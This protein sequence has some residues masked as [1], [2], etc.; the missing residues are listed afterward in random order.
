M[1][2]D[3][4][5]ELIS[6]TAVLLISA[7]CTSCATRQEESGKKIS[8]EAAKIA[9]LFKSANFQGDKGNNLP[10]R[11]FEPGAQ[12]DSATKY[13]VIL[14]LH[15]EDEFGTDNEA[16]VTTTECAT[17]WVEPDHLAKNPAYVL[18]PQAPKGSD[19]TTEPV[20]S[21]TLALLYQFIKEHP[22]VDSRRI[23][24]V[25]FSAGADGVW[26]IIL[27]NPK[28]FAAAMPISGN[29]DTYLGDHEAWAALKNMPIYIIHSYDDTVS[30]ISSSINAVA[31]LQRVGN[32]YVFSSSPNPS[33]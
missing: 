23:Y 12:S 16:Q 24:I 7:I 4:F 10:Y 21:S 2:K 20:Y 29:A 22:D 19:W 8:A 13:P 3:A 30:P 18:A 9:P 1:K 5:K 33:L 26:N 25:G 14:Y 32:R 15:G 27:K 17:I 28:L 31:A 6:I 11:Y